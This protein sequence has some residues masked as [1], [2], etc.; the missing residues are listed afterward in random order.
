MKK[1]RNTKE[2]V[3]VILTMRNAATTILHTLDSLFQQ[4]YPISE[5]IIFDNVSNDNSVQL[6]EEYRKKKKISILLIKRKENKGVAVNYNDGAKRAKSE[7]IIFMHSDSALPS[8]DEIEKLTKPLRNDTRVVATYSTIILP[9]E[10][11]QSYNFWQQLLFNR[12]VGRESP[13]L[14]GKFDCHRRNTFLKIGGFDDKY[15]GQGGTIGGED[16]DLHLRLQKEGSIVLSDAKVIH[17]HYLGENYSFRDF[18]QN[19]KLLSRTYGRLIRIRWRLLS[20]GALMF[21]IK[22]ILAILPF[23]PYLKIIGVV[24]LFLYA[25]LYTRNMFLSKVTFGN[26][27]IVLLPFVNIF[28]V[29][30]ETFWMV[31]AFLFLKKKV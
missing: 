1:N 17:L 19:R 26:W 7:L 4:E 31:Q 23:L 22:P 11:W 9:K 29:Y 13:G 27:R 20:P 12:S 18:L 21:A 16:G 8:S 10:I 5:I 30:Y 3:T 6:V 2:P 14:N 28:L 15:F 25:F 24:L